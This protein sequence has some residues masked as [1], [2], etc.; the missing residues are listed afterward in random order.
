MP[1]LFDDSNMETQQIAGSGFSFQGARLEH[2]GATEYT[3]VTIAIDVTGSVYEFADELRKMLVTAVEACQKSPRSDNLLVRVVLFS[4]DVGG[5]QELHGFKPLSEINPADYPRFQPGGLTTLYDAA[6]SSIGAM[7]QYGADLMENDFLANGIV[8]VVTDGYDNASSSR[9]KMIAQEVK[10]AR[11]EEKLE[12]L[13]AILIG[14]NAADC[15][16][17]LEDF[18]REAQLDDYIDAGDVTPGKLAKVADF[19]SHSVSSTSQALGTG[20]PSQE[21]SATI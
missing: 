13:M 6:F 17:F 8:F 11:K 12:S 10:Q 1:R 19:V 21:I 2:L 3:L 5:V 16:D 14:I 20:G 18:Q 15:K 9:P 7:I 4:T